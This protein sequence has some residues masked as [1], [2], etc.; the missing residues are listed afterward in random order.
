[1]FSFITLNWRG[2]PLVSYETVVNLISAT[3]TRAGL[4]VKAILDPRTYEAGT[5][6]SDEEMKAIR[7]ERHARYPDWNYT[8]KPAATKSKS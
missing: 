8:I 5:K 4:R 6:I 2:Q 1:M 7:L 3:R